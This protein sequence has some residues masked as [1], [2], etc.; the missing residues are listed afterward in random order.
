MECW[1]FTPSEYRI[2]EFVIDVDVYSP[3]NK[4][5][6]QYSRILLDTGYD[7][8]LL[9]SENDFVNHGFSRALSIESERWKAESVS[10]EEILLLTSYSEIRISQQN[11]P[12]LIESFKGNNVSLIG[13]GVL[14]L[15]KTIIDGRDEKTCIVYEN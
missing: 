14:S 11:F 3:Q 15:V 10:G 8:D 13:R 6:V 9:I 1:T 2:K 12:V 5:W 7:G 4:K